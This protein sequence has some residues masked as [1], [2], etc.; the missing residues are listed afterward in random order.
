MV[1]GIPI[2]CNRMGRCRISMQHQVVTSHLQHDTSWLRP[3]DEDVYVRKH[4]QTVLLDQLWTQVCWRHA[5]RPGLQRLFEA[6]TSCTESMSPCTN[7]PC[8]GQHLP[9][10][11]KIVNHE[12]P[13]RTHRGA[14]AVSQC[15]MK[16]RTVGSLSL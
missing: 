6:A 15:C 10:S 11:H 16:D 4:L 1:A 7:A 9:H 14:R 8:F 12:P 2:P 5:P 13:G 3:Q